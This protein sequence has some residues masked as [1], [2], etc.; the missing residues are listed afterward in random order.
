MAKS[1]LS[2][3]QTYHQLHTQNQEKKICKKKQKR[4]SK[5][6][7]KEQQQQQIEINHLRQNATGQIDQQINS[8]NKIIYVQK[9]N[10]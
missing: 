4:Q 2:S 5:K 8:K 3:N 1:I 10:H 9:T 6:R 7:R